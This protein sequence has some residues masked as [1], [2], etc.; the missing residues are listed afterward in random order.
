MKKGDIDLDEIDESLNIWIRYEQKCILKD[1]RYLNQVKCTLGAYLDD[2]GILRLKGRLGNSDIPGK[3]PI[4]LPSKNRFTELLIL[5]CHKTVLH[6]GM[7]DTLNELRTKYW[8][9]RG[10]S[11]VQS[12]IFS[13][14]MQKIAV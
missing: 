1:E 5:D 2:G 12:V 4:L 7:K 10:R 14:L 8:V 13:C 3:Y 6:S 11:R 9:P